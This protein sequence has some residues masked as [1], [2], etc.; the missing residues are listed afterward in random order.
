MLDPNIFGAG[1]KIVCVSPVRNNEQIC[2]IEMNE[3][4]K[5][6]AG[7]HSFAIVFTFPSKEEDKPIM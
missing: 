6:T 3:K 4:N 1:T 5:Q 2:R 7:I